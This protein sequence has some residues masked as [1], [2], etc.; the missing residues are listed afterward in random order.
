MVRSAFAVRGSQHEG[1]ERWV[2]RAKDEPERT[3]HGIF[4][5]DRILAT[6][7]L[8]DFEMRFR[9][10][11]LSMGGIGLLCSRLDARGKGSVREMLVGALG[12][13]RDR[14]HVVSVL[15]PFNKAF[16]RKYGWEDFE[17][18]Q[19]IDVSP[20]FLE[21]P[22]AK[23]GYQVEDLPFPDRE[24]VDYYNEYAATHYTLVLRGDAEWRRRT[25]IPAWATE[26]AT[27]GVIRIRK[28][29]RVVGLIG[30]ELVRKLGEEEPTFVANLFLTEDEPA[31]Q[32]GLRF[33][34][35]LSHQV[36]AIRFELPV[37]VSLWPY[38][39]D[40]PGSHS[41]HDLFMIRVVS[42]KDLDGLRIACGDLS[43]SVDVEDRQAPW[44]ARVWR[45]EVRDGVLRVSEGDRPDLRCGVG[46]LSSILSGYTD[47]ASM[48]AVG[49]C[50]ALASYEGQDLPRTV[51]F[52]A[53]YF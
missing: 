4:D 22:G 32:A 17:R 11:V 20:G 23:G 25:D 52:L 45:L 18:F 51:T 42:M 30:Y 21:I 48:I 38:L 26:T 14:G 35:S 13:M 16:Y 15:S 24:T 9:E 34:K 1:L 2:R 12:T 31:R 50:E 47:F 29:T 5:G 33:L 37:D 7:T 53:D 46:T 10:S 19:R 43:L 28:D 41:I 44:N 39:N 49:R 36:K 8:Y 40:A 6:Y 27:R 3:I